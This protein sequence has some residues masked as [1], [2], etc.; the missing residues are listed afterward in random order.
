MAAIASLRHC[1]K[2]EEFN[3]V[4]KGCVD[5]GGVVIGTGKIKV[6]IEEVMENGMSGVAIGAVRAEEFA[7]SDILKEPTLIPC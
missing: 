2:L 3:F 4:V 5:I 6:V 1:K 7:D